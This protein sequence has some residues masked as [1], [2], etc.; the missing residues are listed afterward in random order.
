MSKVF[1][2]GGA[3][4]IGSHVADE[5]ISNGHEVTIVDNLSTGRRLNIAH[6]ADKIQFIEADIRDIETYKHLLDADTVIVNL[7]AFVSVPQ[8]IESPTEAHEI[9]VDGT[10][11]LMV[12]AK[13]KGVKKF[14]SASSAAVYGTDAE[15]PVKETSTH[16]P[17]S[18]YGLHKS[19]NEQYGKMYSELYGTNYIFFRFFN[20]YGPRQAISGGYAA[21]I[22][23]FI[24]K[25]LLG[26]APQIFGDGETSRDF[27]FV[28]DI[29][30]QIRLAVEKSTDE[31]EK[32]NV[33]NVGTGKETTLNN[34][35][36]SIA[37]AK[38]LSLKVRFFEIRN[39]FGYPS[40]EVRT[41]FES[42]SGL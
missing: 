40:I 27:I 15:V 1:L 33:F 22:P 42:K 10:H 39:S 26:Q 9:N 32:F 23:I 21:V 19:I 30:K 16:A 38:N 17:C 5:L 36:K 6:V 4:F 29:A 12:A 20:V 8:S 34:L 31:L 25:A 37:K 14:I 2:T 24:Q 35:W 28:K 3:G 11:A 18:P 7:A 13:E 41:R